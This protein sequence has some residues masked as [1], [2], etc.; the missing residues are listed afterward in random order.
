MGDGTI[1]PLEIV[2]TESIGIP[3]YVL[4]VLVGAAS[5]LPHIRCGAKCVAVDRFEPSL[6]GIGIIQSLHLVTP[7]QGA[8]QKTVLV[9][10]V[11]GLMLSRNGI[12][13]A[14]YI[15]QQVFRVI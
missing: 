6:Q 4:R 1:I 15:R 2:Q 10:G 8:R 14:E 11:M 9:I 13:T 12:G 7:Q 3:A 5:I